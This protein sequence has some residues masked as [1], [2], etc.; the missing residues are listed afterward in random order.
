MSLVLSFLLMLVRRRN[1][2]GVKANPAAIRSFIYLD[3]EPSVQSVLRGQAWLLE[4][5]SNILSRTTFF[6][7]STGSL[8]AVQ[9]QMD[10]FSVS[11]NSFFMAE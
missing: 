4:P 11:F 8:F 1:F 3:S 2:S 5:N 7:A 6:I 10:I 9:G